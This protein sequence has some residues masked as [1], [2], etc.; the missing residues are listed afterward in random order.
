MGIY[1]LYSKKPQLHFV[2]NLYMCVILFLKLKMG[3]FNL[4]NLF[5]LIIIF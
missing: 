2:P 5:V 3:F 4:L 1:L